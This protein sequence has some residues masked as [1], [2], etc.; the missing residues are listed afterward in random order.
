MSKINM[1]ELLADREKIETLI[2]NANW[3]RNALYGRE[4]DTDIVKWDNHGNNL[5]F[6]YSELRRLPDLEAAF[7]EAVEALEKIA[8][9]EILSRGR[10]W[11]HVVGSMQVLARTTLERVTSND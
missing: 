8:G 7:I 1:A 9:S 6:I 3:S 5:S 10:H 2:F 4:C 11:H